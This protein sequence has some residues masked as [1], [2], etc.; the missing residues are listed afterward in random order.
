MVIEKA[1][2]PKPLLDP[3]DSV[4]QRIILMGDSDIYPDLLE[5][6]P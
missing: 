6:I 2:V 4:N 5:P 3:K 1:I